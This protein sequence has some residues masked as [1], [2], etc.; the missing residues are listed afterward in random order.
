MNIVI[1]RASVSVSENSQQSSGTRFETLWKSLQDK[2]KE[3]ERIKA[4]TESLLDLYQQ[5]LLPVE[6]ELTEP[7]ALLAERL[8]DFSRR[9]SLSN[10][11]RDELDT[12]L[13]ELIS[14]IYLFDGARAD[15]LRNQY[16]ESIAFQQGMTVEELEAEFL[17]AELEEEAMIDEFES[18][19]SGVAEEILKEK[20][21]AED[22]PQEDMFGFSEEELIQTFNDLFEES[23]NTSP[24]DETF[25]QPD[26]TPGLNAQPLNSKWIRS[27]F[28][29]TAQALHP[30]KETDPAM[31]D[32]KHQLM[33]QLLEA[34]EREREDIMTMLTLYNEHVEE[35]EFTVA[36]QDA[37]SLCIMLENQLVQMEEELEAY[38][39]E[40]P[41]RQAAYDRL[42]SN[43]TRGR[44]KRLKDAIKD[45]REQIELTD[46]L[47]L[48]LRNLNCLKEALK[49]RYDERYNFF[50]ITFR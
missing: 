17:A 41:F 25:D 11:H 3:H 20:Q 23:G 45:I 9:K 19:F 8:I 39:T 22:S 14:F 31:R 38:F 42:Y 12:W 21:A 24:N 34:R 50:D 37:E 44:Q 6:Q 4:D 32:H 40:H 27:I 18:I 15:E 48:Y 10:W 49:Q 46:E 36:A 7:L 26:P 5:K 28:R 16:K 29:R 2:R 35:G 47:R 1:D 13:Q 43:S 30:D 33:S